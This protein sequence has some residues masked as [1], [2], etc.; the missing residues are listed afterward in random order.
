ME[1]RKSEDR[2]A[3]QD[4]VFGTVIM[5]KGE[6]CMV[7]DAKA[8]LDKHVPVVTLEGGLEYHCPYDEM[9]TPVKAHVELD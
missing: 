9:F 8:L 3:I 2:K 6:Y 4:T 1:I 5:Y 7:M